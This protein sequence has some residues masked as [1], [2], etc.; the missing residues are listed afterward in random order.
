MEWA[1]WVGQVLLLAALYIIF[2]R[3]GLEFTHHHDTVSLVWPPTGLS[4]AALILFGRRL[5]PGVFIG[6]L[7][8]NMNNGL[9]WTTATGVAI[10]NALEALVGVTL[11]VRVA[12]FRPNMERPRDGVAFLVFGVLGCTIVSAT[13]G[14]GSL[15]L[16]GALKAAEFEMAWLYWWLGDVGGALIV[17][18]FILMLVHGTPSWGSLAR[19][20]ESWFILTTLLVT[21]LFVFFG[22]DLG[23]L[24]FAASVAPFSVLVWA[25]TRLGPRG[26]LMASI[27]DILIATLATGAGSGPFVHGTATEDMFML[28]SYS[29]FIGASAF[30]LAA[31]TEQRDVAER[32]YRSEEAERLRTEKQKLLLMERE[33]LTREMHDGLGG[34]LVSVLSMVERGMADSDEIA[35]GVRRAIDDI[36]IVIDSLDSHTMSLPMSLGK[37]RS[38]LEPQLRRNGIALQWSIDDIPGLD[39]FPPEAMLQV[40]RI[41]Q[42]AVTNTLRHANAGRVEVRISASGT[43][44]RQLHVSIHDDGRGLATPM[45]SGGRGIRSMKARAR[46]L[47][48]VLHIEGASSGTQIDLAIPFSR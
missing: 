12:D 38:R 26:A 46:E 45:S 8:V 41:I 2:G 44:R 13:I 47:G 42:E 20:R 17:T 30:T 19:R 33:R 28:W 23:V 1:T 29:I 43:Q 14:T 25:G 22:P 16:S 34:Q 3:F 37:L 27:L 36:G 31:V 5:W 32:R 9:A 21:S 24:G 7:L 40:M 6:A 48:G 11:L 39:V 4:L 15:L 35:E 18:P 10:G